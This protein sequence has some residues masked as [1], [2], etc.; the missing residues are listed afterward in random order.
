MLNRRDFVKIAAV[1]TLPLAACS[2]SEQ[3]GAEDEA[4]RRHA[5]QFEP[6][7]DAVRKADVPYDVEPL[8]FVS[9]L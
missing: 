1:G 9:L 7:L 6:V 5:A 3:P 2:A 8:F 4:V